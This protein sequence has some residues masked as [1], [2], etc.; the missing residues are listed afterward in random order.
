VRALLGR[1]SYRWLALAV[2]TAVTVAGCGGSSSPAKPKRPA[3]ERAASQVVRH[4]LAAVA[5]GN[6]AVACGLMT[7]GYQARVVAGSTSTCAHALGAVAKSLTT[8]EKATLDQAEIS[9]AKLSSGKMHVYVKG[10][11]GAAALTKQGG[12]WLISGGAAT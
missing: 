9:R 4:W 1:A 5:A 2:V 10:E 8:A 3:D 12:H 7:K 6:G 11:K